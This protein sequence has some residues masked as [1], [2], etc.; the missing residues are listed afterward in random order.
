MMHLIP[1]NLCIRRICDR[2][3]S[4][5]TQTV[6]NPPQE[7]TIVIISIQAYSKPT[8]AGSN[9]ML[10][11]LVLA[12]ALSS[13]TCRLQYVHLASST[14]LGIPRQRSQSSSRHCIS[15]TGSAF[16]TA[17][18]STTTG[19]AERRLCLLFNTPSSCSRPYAVCSARRSNDCRHSLEQHS[20][21][22]KQRPRS[23]GHNLPI[24]NITRSVAPIQ[25]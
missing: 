17:A 21:A 20:L 10:V 3:T 16:V 7:Y 1:T 19:L 8:A 4:P 13:M 5:A 2:R 14:R 11:R 24:C 15:D 25:M 6:P 9:G 23:M 18:S 12:A 22:E